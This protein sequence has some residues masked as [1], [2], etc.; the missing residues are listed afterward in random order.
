MQGEEERFC[1]FTVYL[2]HKEKIAPSVCRGIPPGYARYIALCTLEHYFT[3]ASTPARM[4]F[5]ILDRGYQS[6]P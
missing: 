3:K 2:S 1:L 5:E 4:E 6:E